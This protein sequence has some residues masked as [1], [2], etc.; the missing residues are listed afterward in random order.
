[1]SPRP[2]D[3]IL[4]CSV[5]VFFLFKVASVRHYCPQH[6]P[7]IVL[8]FVFAVFG[9]LRRSWVRGWVVR[10]FLLALLAGCR[11]VGGC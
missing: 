8:R 7:I 2:K 10:G 1:M 11:D 4:S 9:G 3:I 6:I 5:P